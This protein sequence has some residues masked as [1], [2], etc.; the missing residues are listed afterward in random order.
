MLCHRAP[1]MLRHPIAIPKT[2]ASRRLHGPAPMADSRDSTE[3]A[4]VQWHP[5]QDPDLRSCL[6]EQLPRRA[7][8]CGEIQVALF[9]VGGVPAGAR[10]LPI[11]RKG[12]ETA[13]DRVE[14]HVFDRGQNRLFGGEIAIVPRPFLPEAE[15][16]FS[17][18]LEHGEV[19]DE[20]TLLFDESASKRLS[21]LRT[22]SI[23]SQ[24]KAPGGPYTCRNSLRAW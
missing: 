21:R 24:S 8:D 10:P 9:A 11:D 20:R 16:F 14:V 18:P 6:D 4:E 15:R 7:V 17:G 1:K 5:S 19:R 22:N 23:K 3:L 12:R 13:A 2:L